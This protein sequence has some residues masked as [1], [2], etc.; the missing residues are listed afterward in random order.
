MMRTLLG[1]FRHGARMFARAPGFTA[2]AVA[3]LAIGIGAN[4]AI[5]SVVNTVLIQPLPYDDPGRLAAI[6]EHN[7]PR[8]RKNNSISPGNFI[9]WREMQQSFVDIAAVGGRLNSPLN[10]TI[11]GD[12]EPEE[13]R[14]QFVSAAFFPVLGVNAAHGRVFTAEE[15]RPQSRVAVISH[16]LWARRFGS[17]RNILQRPITIQGVPYTV[18]GVMPPAFAY[19]DKGVDVWLPVGFSAQARTPRGRWLAAVGRLKPGVTFEQAQTDMAR[20]HAELTRL[21]PEFNT[22]WTARVVP[23]T[24]EL[25]GN[26]KPALLVL[27]GAVG[28]VLLIA[29]ANVANLLLARATTRQREL[30]VRSALG[31]ARGRIVRQL[32]AEGLVLATAGGLAGLLLAWWAI[33][34]ARVAVA[35]QIPIHRLEAVQLDGWVLLFTLAASLLS[36]VL[37]GIVPAL[38][39]SG[40]TLT[41]ALKEGGRTG[42]SRRGKY[43][44]NALAVVE[45]ALALVLLVG[46]GLLVRSFIRLLGVDPGFNTERVVTMNITLPR[47][48]YPEP[49]QQVQFYQRLLGRVETLPGVEAASVNSFLPFTGLGA[50]TGFEVVG[51]P[52]PAAGEEPVCDVRVIANDYFKAM[53][54]PLLKGRLFAEDEALDSTDKVIVNET[55]AKKYWPN[56]DPIGKKIKISWNDDREDEIIGVVGDVRHLALETEPRA[57]TYWPYPRFPY[58][59]MALA[60]RTAN[61]P[62]SSAQSVVAIVRELDPNLAVAGIKTLDDL[63]SESVAQRRLTMLLLAIFAAAALAL[64]AVGIYGLIAYSV[65]QRTQEIGIRMALGAKAGDVLRM[66]LGQAAALAAAGIAVGA[67]GAAVL[68]RFMAG[69]LYQVEPLDAVTFLLVAGVLAAVAILAAFVPGRRAAAVDP[70]IALRAE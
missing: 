10:V 35:E 32:I 58:T 2:V 39:A 57:M 33:S 65:T 52:K 21:F 36:G 12:G 25:T 29:C 38:S 45:I 20:A 54:I 66:V 27:L 67:V 42:T 5:F 61:D 55:L 59:A 4:T 16:R 63:V 28:F 41:D 23:L 22:G 46:A 3:A 47:V 6:W 51:Q 48:R 15:D 13:I 26:I 31:A 56:E 11:T 68:T 24:D 30:A 14:M 8:D 9:H 7:L 53:G 60:I 50:A 64:A 19:M 1:D 34:V 43:V 62:L 44:R 40:A 49:A 37:F 69:M 18:L 70:V 17:D